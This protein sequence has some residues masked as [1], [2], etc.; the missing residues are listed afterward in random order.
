MPIFVWTLHMCGSRCAFECNERCTN[1]MGYIMRTLMSEFVQYFSLSL[2]LLLNIQSLNCHF[3]FLHFGLVHFVVV[4]S[5]SV[6]CLLSTRF[7]FSIS[8]SMAVFCSFCYSIFFFSSFFI[9]YI[10]VV[11]VFV[12]V[13]WHYIMMRLRMLFGLLRMYIKCICED[14]DPHI[15]KVVVVVFS[16][17]NWDSGTHVQ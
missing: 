9:V 15:M 13:S 3:C 1:S 4:V 14:R 5:F 2:V 6:L 7:L 10:T 8:F 12:L 16:V 11:F 17:L